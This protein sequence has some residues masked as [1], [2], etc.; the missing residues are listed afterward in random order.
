HPELLAFPEETAYF[1]TV[2]TK[3]EPRGR[4]AQFDYLTKH[5][6]SRGLFGVPRES[7]KQSYAEF[8]TARFLELFE[9]KAFAPENSAKDLLVLMIE[10]YAEILGRLLDSIRRWIEKTPANRKYLP[11]IFARF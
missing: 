3:Y 6:P 5:A 11:Q 9:Q 4:R 10:A 2:L 1:P 7:W 8:S